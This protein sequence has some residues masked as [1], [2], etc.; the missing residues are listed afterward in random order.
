MGLERNHSLT[1]GMETVYGDGGATPTAMPVF[2]S[3][4]RPKLELTKNENPVYG[5]SLGRNKVFMGKRF[6]TLPAKFFLKGSGTAGTPPEIA[7]ILKMAGLEEVD[8]P[9]DD[10]YKP[11][12]TGHE[13][14]AITLNLDGV[15]YVIAGA[16]CE[17]LTIPIEA[18]NPVICEAQFVGLY[19]APTAVAL[20]A[21]TFADAAV[22]PPIAE[23][24]ALTIGGNTH[25]IP[26]FTLELANVRGMR[27]SINS[28]TG[29][30]QIDIIGRD[31]GG[32]FTVEVDANNDIEYWTN[33]LAATEMAIASTGFGAAGNR[34]AISTST[35][36]LD[37]ITPAVA[38]GM[39]LYEVTFRI[40][41][42]ATAASELSITFT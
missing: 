34:I 13:S 30:K 37:D 22:T 5:G 35:L 24:M 6:V 41:K 12:N 4:A 18:G 1:I 15:Q 11:R 2:Y 40:N 9:S 16:R 23:S 20:S 33:L 25:I 10:V 36:Q 8:G 28:A 32:S 21:P 31:W 29:L 17:K 7:K 3:D 39:N 19:A 38:E 26:K 14:G 27:E 42:H